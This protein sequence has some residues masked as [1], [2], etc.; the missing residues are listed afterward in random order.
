MLTWVRECENDNH[1]FDRA[2]KDQHVTH[3]V[4]TVLCFQQMVSESRCHLL[5]LPHCLVSWNLL[6][7]CCLLE[8]LLSLP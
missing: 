3:S 5:W 8:L 1:L 7:A 4:K 6:S 2:M